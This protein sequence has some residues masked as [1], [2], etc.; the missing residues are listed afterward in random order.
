MI[1]LKK[2]QQ[3][4]QKLDSSKTQLKLSKMK[5]FNYTIVSSFEKCDIPL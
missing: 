2:K 3:Y 5:T 4:W 1:Y